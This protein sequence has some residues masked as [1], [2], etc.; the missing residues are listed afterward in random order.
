M[1]TK[2]LDR[3]N[4]EEAFRIMGRYLL[5]RN[6]LGEIAIYGGSAILFQFDWRRT[7][8]DVDAKPAYILAM[9]LNALERSTIDDRDFADA[10]DLATACGVR[11]AQELRAIYRSFFSEQQLPATAEL[12]LAEL[13]RAIQSRSR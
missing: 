2:E 5:E 10:V 12:R 9:K 1:T 6:A 13:A 11:T 7:S 8:E 4:I 3:A